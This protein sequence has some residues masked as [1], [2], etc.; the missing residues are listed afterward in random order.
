M[1]PNPSNR[2]LLAWRIAALLS[3]ALM[4]LVGMQLPQKFKIAL[5]FVFVA[6]AL[7]LITWKIFDA[8]LIFALCGVGLNLVFAKLWPA[9]AQQLG[10]LW[11]VLAKLWPAL[12][13]TLAKSWPAL[14]DVKDWQATYFV[15]IAA[16]GFAALIKFEGLIDDFASILADKIGNR[17]NPLLLFG[18]TSSIAFVVNAIIM[19]AGSS[20]AVVAPLFVPML[21][22]LRFPA[23][24]AAAAVVIG[25]WGGFLNPG[26]TGAGAINSAFGPN[27]YNIPAMH[28]GPAI[29]ALVAANIM[30]ALMNRKKNLDSPGTESEADSKEAPS[31]IN[32][33][34][35]PDGR[36]TESVTEREAPPNGKGLIRVIIVVLPFLLLLP[37]EFLGWFL[38]LNLNQYFKVEYRLLICLVVASLAASVVVV[39]DSGQG[40][41]RVLSIVKVFSG[42]MWKGFAEVIVLIAAAKLLIFPFQGIIEHA[43]PSLSKLAIGFVPTAFLASAMIGS[44]DAV[45]QILIPTVIKLTSQSSSTPSVAVAGMYAS[46][47]WLATEMG[48]S[49]SAISAATLTCARA[50]ES[51]EIDAPTIASHALWPILVAFVIGCFALYVVFTVFT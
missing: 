13:Q 25:A 35:N 14:T 24:V 39:R 7:L 16:Y 28:I 40:G 3:V 49:V 47:L 30:F 23:S 2:H 26:D 41:K 44:G 33:K 29:L 15:I 43:A 20:C 21:I 48:R 18:A 32:R 36:S 37:L 11:L 31:N 46:M 42:G 38:T 17:S 12:A 22:R 34:K 4:T 51:Q 10:T 19:S 9:L 27:V 1:R 45:A 6:G 5:A 50:L 8:R